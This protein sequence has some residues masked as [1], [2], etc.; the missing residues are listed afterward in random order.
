MYIYMIYISIHIYIYILEIPRALRARFTSF[1]SWPGPSWLSAP[2][3]S[4]LWT[5]KGL[6]CSQGAHH[7]KLQEDMRRLLSD[8]APD[9]FQTG[10]TPGAPQRETGAFLKGLDRP[11]TQKSFGMSSG[12]IGRNHRILNAPMAT[13]APCRGLGGLAGHRSDPF[14][15]PETCG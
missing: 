8:T 6:E 9:P 14:G 11:R 2:P 15:V 5:L 3:L 12:S 1:G 4:P 7:A 10:A 13:G